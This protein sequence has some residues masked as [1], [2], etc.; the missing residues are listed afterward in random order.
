MPHAPFLKTKIESDQ[1]QKEN[2]RMDREFIPSRST[3]PGILTA[4]R[5][6]RIKAKTSQ[7]TRMAFINRKKESV[8]IKADHIRTIKEVLREQLET[9]KPGNEA[10]EIAEYI[11]GQIAGFI[12]DHYKPKENPLTWRNSEGHQIAQTIKELEDEINHKSNQIK[13]LD[14]DRIALDTARQVQQETAN[15]LRAILKSAKDEQ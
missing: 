9:I 5:K 1:T 15:K 3:N 13:M 4:N 2:I 12:S 11:G 10:K 6:T 8:M 14:Q 7:R